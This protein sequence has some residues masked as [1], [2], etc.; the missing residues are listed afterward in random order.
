MEA[1][2]LHSLCEYKENRRRRFRGPQNQPTFFRHFAIFGHFWPNWPK[3]DRSIF[4]IFPSKKLHLLSLHSQSKP[5]YGPTV[6]SVRF[7][8]CQNVYLSEIALYKMELPI[9]RATHYVVWS[10]RDVALRLTKFFNKHYSI[11]LIPNE[12]LRKNNSI[13]LVSSYQVHFLLTTL[14]LD[15]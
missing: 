13:L 15:D 4:F 5:K 11:H 8:K 1:I 14:G 12:N 6:L 2:L 9:L 3:C 7:A 10:L